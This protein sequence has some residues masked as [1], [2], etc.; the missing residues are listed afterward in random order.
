MTTRSPSQYQGAVI[1]GV[2]SSVNAS[3]RV[4]G[5]ADMTLDFQSI[6]VRN[7][8]TYSFDGVIETMR[9]P[10]GETIRVDN[11]GTVEDNSSQTGKTVQRGAIGAALGALIGA[12]AGGSK[13]AAIGAVIGAGGGAG[14]V[15]A[16][17]RGQLDLQRGTEVTITSSDA[18][19]QKVTGGGPR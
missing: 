12:I 1:E 11:A 16:E 9:T 14:T 6:R 7:G 3:G 15:I 2:V 5:R 4:S 19:G 17:G 10:A 8:G 18:R 13:G